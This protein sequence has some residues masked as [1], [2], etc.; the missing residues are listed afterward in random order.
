MDDTIFYGI[1]RGIC[2]TLAYFDDKTQKF[3]FKSYDS[4]DT[5]IDLGVD[6]L[7]EIRKFLTTF[8][9]PNQELKTEYPTD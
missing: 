7:S 4:L 5:Y 8:T 6:K 3:C 1:H 9:R 2:W